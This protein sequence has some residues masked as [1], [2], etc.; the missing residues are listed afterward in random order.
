MN[1]LGRVTI[2]I[3][4]YSFGLC[5]EMIHQ[6]I[7]CMSQT[8]FSKITLK[9]KIK[10]F[11]SLRPD[12]SF[13]C[14]LN[15]HFSCSYSNSTTVFPQGP[16]CQHWFRHGTGD[17][18]NQCWPSSVTLLGHNDKIKYF[19]IQYQNISQIFVCMQLIILRLTHLLKVLYRWK[20]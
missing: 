6:W 7:A 12:N 3:L 10:A 18:L 14:I 4:L 16:Y 5:F 15:E 1:N 2:C 20:P 19:K 11:N 17:K 13:N 9:Y 8:M